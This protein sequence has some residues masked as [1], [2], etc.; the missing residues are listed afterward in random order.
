MAAAPGQG[1]RTEFTKGLAARGP[2][3]FAGLET[4]KARTGRAFLHL[5]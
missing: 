4:E 3:S 5:S 2:F 1:A